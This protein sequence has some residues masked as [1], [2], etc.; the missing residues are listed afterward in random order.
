MEQ[1]SVKEKF[2]TEIKEIWDNENF[3]N[4][5]VIKRGFGIQ[6][7]I[8]KKSI[9]FI[10]I[11][12]SFDERK[13]KPSQEFYNISQTGESHPYFNK[14]KIIAGNQNHHWT[15]FD[16]LFFRETNQRYVNELLKK[17]NGVEFIYRQLEVSKKVLIEAKPK[18]LIISNTM[19][20]HFTGFEKNQEQTQGVWMGFD[21]VFDEK[22]GTHKIVNN[23]DLDNT[24]VFFTS[25]LT[26]QRA[27]DKGSFERLNWHINFVLNQIN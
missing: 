15:H 25:M 9:M 6:D 3:R 5:E 1:F 10:G 8:L 16:L 12:P 26:G 23:S 17:T 11:N 18:V 19:A 21:F 7:I 24:P 13:D 2:E 14:F 20:R 4:F 22:L 27:L